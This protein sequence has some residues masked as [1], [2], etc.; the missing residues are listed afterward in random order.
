MN[1]L[2]DIDAFAA[3]VLATRMT[4]AAALVVTDQREPLAVRTYGDAPAGCLWQIGSI[5]K[6]FTAV[7]ALQLAEE[8]LLDLHAP[9]AEYLPWFSVRSAFPPITMHH[10]LTH[11]AGIVQGAEIATASTYD[12]IA[13]AETQAAYAPGEHFWYSNVGYRTVGL[14]LEAVTGEP[15]PDQVQR[16]ILDPLGMRGS[17]PVIT[18]E[19]R[20][21]MPQGHTA[22]FD[23]RPWRPEHGL[24]PATWIESAEADGCICCTI[25]DLAAWLRALWAEDERV[26]SRAGFQRM[27]SALVEDDQEGGR[28]GFGLVVAEDGFGHSG[29]MLGFHTQLWADTRRGLGAVAAVNG[30]GGARV[31][32]HGALAIA[33]GEQPEDPEPEP[34]APM[35]DDGSCP[36][37]WLPYLGHYRS[38][39]PWASNFR[40]VGR[41]GGLQFGFD[42]YWSERHPMTPVGDAE[43]RVG[44]QAWAPERLRFDTILDGRAQRAILSGGHFHRTFTE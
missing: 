17:T 8:G 7:L 33:H 27:K 23:D 35:A 30:I 24:A 9:V 14:V 4:P 38:H 29:G 21:R 3:R 28:Y 12:V 16:R 1:R 13:L 42:C 32:C 10:L 25:D 37:E 20:G 2:T 11:T 34:A 41:E 22:F 26:L 5:G 43:F 36:A 31:L 19:L 39:N 40:V 15:Y 44:E 18:N 6:S